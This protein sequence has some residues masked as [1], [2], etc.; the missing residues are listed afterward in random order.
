[1]KKI[2]LSAML[3]GLVATTAVQ[4][5]PATTNTL[6][7]AQQQETPVKPEDLP[8]P[9]KQVLSG[10]EYKDWSIVTAYKSTVDGKDIY[11]INFKKGEETKLIKFNPDGSVVTE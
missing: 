6:V 9:I 10:D 8:A 11:K 3:L 4:A 2:I 5:T 7:A 1:M